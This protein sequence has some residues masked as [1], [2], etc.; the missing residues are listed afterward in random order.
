MIGACGCRPER[1]LKVSD[2]H[3][4]PF[5][6]GRDQR[7]VGFNALTVRG[8]GR[9]HRRRKH[10]V[11]PR[12]ASARRRTPSARDAHSVH[13]LRRHR[14]VRSQPQARRRG[15]FPRLRSLAPS[16]NRTDNLP[17][18]PLLPSSSEGSFQVLGRSWR[19]RFRS[20]GPSSPSSRA[21]VPTRGYSKSETRE[22]PSHTPLGGQG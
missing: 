1:H 9:D 2:R 5:G 19:V 10:R 14:P 8:R 16:A 15:G 11:Q 13:G 17:K 12:P 21:P 7:N 22:R 6:Q 18:C 20:E 4:G 3:I